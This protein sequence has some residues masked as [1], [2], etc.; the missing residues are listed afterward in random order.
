MKMHKGFI[1][2]GSKGNTI[3]IDCIDKEK[4]YYDTRIEKVAL[5]DEYGNRFNIDPK[6]V[7]NKLKVRDYND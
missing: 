6:L 3:N 7:T 2:L 4:T 5:I 1:S